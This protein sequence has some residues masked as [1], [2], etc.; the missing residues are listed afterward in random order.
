M[1]TKTTRAAANAIAFVCCSLVLAGCGSLPSMPS[2]SIGLM[3]RI[4]VPSQIAAGPDET[5]VLIGAG[6]GVQVYRCDLTAG[7]PTPSNTYEWVL[8]APDAV[9]RDPSERYLGKL[10]LG[11]TWEAEDGSKVVGTID[12]RRDATNGSIPWLRLKVRSTGGPGTLNGVT[13]VIRA[14]TT[15]GVPRAAG[16]NELERGRIARVDYTADY[17]FYARR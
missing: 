9:L 1:N 11:P 15:G 12:A 10:Y 8:Q 5:L 7:G 2:L 17:Y 13:T 14:M 6:T 4:P 16:C 3:P